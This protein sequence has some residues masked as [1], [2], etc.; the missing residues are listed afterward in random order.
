MRRLIESA[1]ETGFHAALG[2]REWQQALDLNNEL[3]NLLRQRMAVKTESVR[4]EFHSHAPLMALGRFDDARELLLR[5]RRAAEQGLD[6]KLLGMV[7]GSQASPSTCRATSRWL[8]A[9]SEKPSATPPKRVI[10]M[11]SPSA[12]STWATST[13]PPKSPCKRCAIT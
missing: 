3:L 10:S 5:V 8:S 7:M 13:S 11:I 9:C 2:L 12:T 6:P 1:L 4:V